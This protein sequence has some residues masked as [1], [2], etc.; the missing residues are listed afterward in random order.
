MTHV[1]EEKEHMAPWLKKKPDLN[2][3]R[4]VLYI[5]KKIIYF[6]KYPSYN[7]VVWIYRFRVMT[8]SYFLKPLSFQII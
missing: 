1:H 6:A 7:K 8:K 2:N 4:N 3:Y 5:S